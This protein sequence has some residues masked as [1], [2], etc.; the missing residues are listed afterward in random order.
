M[1]NLLI[2]S[3][4]QKMKN[5]LFLLFV[6]LTLF[7]C[8]KDFIKNTAEEKDPGLEIRGATFDELPVG[9]QHNIVLGDYRLR[10]SFRDS[11]TPV[12]LMSSIDSLWERRS[13]YAFDLGWKSRSITEL[14]KFKPGGMYQIQTSQIFFDAVD[15]LKAKFPLYTFSLL[16]TIVDMIDNNDI[17]VNRLETLSGMTLMNVYV[18][19]VTD[20]AISILSHSTEFWGDDPGPGPV[21]DAFIIPQVDAAGF[22]IGW[23]WNAWNEYQNN[24]HL[25]IDNQK[26]RINSGCATAMAMST[27]RLIK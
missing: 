9:E 20:G 25:N 15:T 23:G 19:E 5:L 26:T 18:R 17:D 14:N 4:L 7:S 13:I 10:H 22:L 3:N 2:L 1:D 8:E 24:G 27:G 11:I 12:A 16:D 21:S 6:S